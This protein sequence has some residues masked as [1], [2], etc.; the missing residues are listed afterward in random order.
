MAH[1]LRA[2]A[3][4]PK[5]QGSNTHAGKTSVRIKVTLAALPEDL[6]SVPST[7][8]AAHNC[9][10]S[11]RRSNILLTQTYMQANHQCKLKTERKREREKERERKKER[12]RERERKKTK[13]KQDSH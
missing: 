3:A 11:S 7:H 9:N 5:D 13:P 6:G 12:E 10:S 2:L 8:M 1:W 4:L